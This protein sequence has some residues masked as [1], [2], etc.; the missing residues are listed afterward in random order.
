MLFVDSRL[1]TITVYTRHGKANPDNPGPNANDWKNV[2]Y[3]HE[4]YGA[5]GLVELDDVT[6]RH[7]AIYSD[8]NQGLAIRE[9]KIYGRAYIKCFYIFG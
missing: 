2:S 5:I 9:M 8:Y 6:G 3:R 1:A 4:A 7:V